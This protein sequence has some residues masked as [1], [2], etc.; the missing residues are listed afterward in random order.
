MKS[1][2]LWMLMAGMGGIACAQTAVACDETVGACLDTC[3]DKTQTITAQPIAGG[4]AC[5]TDLA[6]AQG[7]DEC[8]FGHCTNEFQDGGES[9]VDCGGMTCDACPDAAACII[10]GDCA[11]GSCVGWSCVADP[12][13]A[14]PAE[15][16]EPHPSAVCALPAQRPDDDEALAA[17]AHF[18]VRNQILKALP[19]LVL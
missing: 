3:A 18:Q 19:C 9:D 16:A 2:L 8:P 12:C 6:C 7:E 14:A 11:S 1:L 5:T 13:A 10:D 4:A 17:L 15:C